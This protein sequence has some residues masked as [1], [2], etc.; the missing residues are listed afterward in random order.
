MEDLASQP[1]PDLGGKRPDPGPQPGW[2]AEEA[3]ERI[4][5]Q[6]FSSILYFFI[7]RGF[8][9]EDARDLTQ[10]TFLRV[11]GGIER[12]RQEQAVKGWI[13]QIAENVYRNRLRD[14]STQKRKGNEVSLHQE[15][16]AFGLVEEAVQKADPDVPLT[17]ILQE[18]QQVLLRQALASLPTQRRLCVVLRIEQEMKYKDIALLLGVSIETVKAHLHQAKNQLRSMLGGYL[19]GFEVLDPDEEPPEGAP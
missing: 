14:S 10:E 6:L 7:G 9:R 5:R 19:S 18:E 13:R 3:F 17:K 2:L 8:S 4:Y 1:P 11:Y 15:G 16:E 12:L